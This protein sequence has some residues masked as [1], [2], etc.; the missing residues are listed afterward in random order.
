V[1]AFLQASGS[2]GELALSLSIGQLVR[3]ASELK[4]DV[5]RLALL[6]ENKVSNV[7]STPLTLGMTD[8]MRLDREG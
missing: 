8:E 5:A 6:L 7:P 1:C 4:N 2:P 3:R